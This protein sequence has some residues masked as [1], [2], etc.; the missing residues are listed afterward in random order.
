MGS[1]PALIQSGRILNIA[2]RGALDSSRTNS[3]EGICE[4]IAFGID[5]IEVDVQITKDGI[6]VLFHDR[7]LPLDGRKTKTKISDQTLSELATLEPVGRGLQITP[8]RAVLDKVH[9]TKTLVVLD[10][11]SRAALDEVTRVIRDA[12]VEAQCLIASFDHL[13][14]LRSKRLSPEI[15]TVLILGRSR[16][17]ASPRG[18]LWTVLALLFPLQAA[19]RLRANAILCP[20]Y[21]LTRRLV[22]KCR[23][24]GIAVF[25]WNLKNITQSCQ[26]L[27]YNV[28]G[29]V[30][31][32]PVAMRHECR[33]GENQENTR[34]P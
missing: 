23:E 30:T 20:A 24:R 34:E 8:L 9:N 4:S 32:W 22:G 13:T 27:D 19:T 26:L 6:P 21:R 5:A 25:V 17:M 3:L 29:M 11:K 2:H 14:L 1:V 31:D 7:S 28:Q 18:F 10:I 33:L 16:V 15:P 12:G